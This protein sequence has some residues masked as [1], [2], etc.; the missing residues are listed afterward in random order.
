MTKVETLELGKQNP[1]DQ[2]E[3]HPHSSTN[4]DSDHC[5]EALSDAP[6]DGGLVAW[7]HAFC[8]HLAVFNAQ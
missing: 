2:Q 6:P 8:G 3:D 1:S 4:T 7:L 5:E